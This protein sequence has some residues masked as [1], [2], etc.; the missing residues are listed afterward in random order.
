[1]ANDAG[2]PAFGPGLLN[3]IAIEAMTPFN[4]A[5][6]VFRCPGIIFWLTSAVLRILPCPFCSSY[7]A[8]WNVSVPREHSRPARL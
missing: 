8:I 5:A 1:M 6:I 4:V 2:T 7:V 3:D